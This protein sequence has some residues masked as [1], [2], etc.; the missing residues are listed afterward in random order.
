MAHYT[1]FTVVITTVAGSLYD[2]L[3]TRVTLPSADGVTTILAQHEP[4]IALLKKGTIILIDESEKEQ[5][6]II[7]NGVLEVSNDKAIILI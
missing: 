4:M 3:A 7:E 1:P 2:G 6:F 5:Q